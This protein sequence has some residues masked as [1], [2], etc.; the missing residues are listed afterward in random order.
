MLRQSHWKGRGVGSLGNLQR[1]IL[2][3]SNSNRFGGS[4][5]MHHHVGIQKERSQLTSVQRCLG[6]VIGRGADGGSEQS[7]KGQ[8]ALNPI[9]TGSAAPL[10]CTIM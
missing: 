6:N 3:K 10:G 7:P 9:I 5:G 1:T 8:F 4:L 2:T